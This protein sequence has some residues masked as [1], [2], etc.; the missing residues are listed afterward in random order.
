[1]GLFPAL[2][3]LNPASP[4]PVTGLPGIAQR[5]A[6]L[7]EKYGDD[8]KGRAVE[9]VSRLQALPAPAPQ[10]TSFT[11]LPANVESSELEPGL[12]SEAARQ[13]SRARDDIYQLISQLKHAEE[14][15]GIGDTDK[16]E[17]KSLAQQLGALVEYAPWWV[18]IMSALCLGIGTMIGYRRIVV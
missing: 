3:A 18:R 17:A 6:P 8:E 9:A 14:S 5:A 10:P 2:F 7:I 11:G 15:K 4:S 12:R 1:I 16:K 13:R